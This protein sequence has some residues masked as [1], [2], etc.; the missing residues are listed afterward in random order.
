MYVLTGARYR[1]NRRN[2]RWEA[3][4]LTQ[5][6]VNRVRN[7]Y[8]DVWLFI[9]YPSL[10]APRALRFDT[11]M[12]WITQA[13]AG[14]TIQQWLTDLGNRTLPFAPTLPTFT[15][16][17]VQYAQAWHA[18]YS[19]EPVVRGG[20]FNPV[21]SRYDKED[22]M[23]TR[24]DLSSQEIATYGMFTVNGLFHMLDY[25]PQGAYILSGHRS[26]V[27]ANDN[28]VGIYS[29]RAIGPLTYIPVTEAMVTGQNDTATLKDG[30]YVTVPESYDLTNKTL[31]L[32]LGGYLQVLGRTYTRVGDRTYKIELSNLMLLER[33]Y[34]S[35][36]RIDLSSLGLEHYDE[37]SSLVEVD[38]LWRDETLRAYM[39]L[40]Q[41]FFVAVEAPT[42]FQEL[43]PLDYAGQPGRYV[44]QTHRWLPVMGSYG[45]MLENHRMLEDGVSLVAGTDNWRHEYDFHHA[46]WT[47]DPAVDDGRY[48][49]LPFRR[50]EAYVRLLGVEK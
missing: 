16:T 12:N 6:P 49:A 10:E 48:P 43:V 40:E 24:P 32:V 29:F 18:G 13:D 17:F 4:D 50:G 11:V 47:R 45:R 33:Y 35:V 22:L 26:M 44:D 27:I 1:K 38:A 31:L 20:T 36:T 3:G 19:F 21:G 34:D 37:N 2:G 23:V 15:P 9:T 5:V 41:T 28:Q 39:T 7:D 42:F 30:I 8:G 14:K 25:N 46:R